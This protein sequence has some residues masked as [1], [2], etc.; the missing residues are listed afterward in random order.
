MNKNAM[1]FGGA[2]V[3]TFVALVIFLFCRERVD[4]GHAGVRVNY[5]GSNA[6]VDPTFI[7]PGVVFYNPFTQGIEEYPT[8][9]KWVVWDGDEALT[10]SD[11][12]GAIINTDIALAL[13]FQ[14]DKV[15]VLYSRTRRS[16]ESIIH[17]Y[18]RILVREKIN[19]ETEKLDVVQIFGEERSKL[20]DR[21]E[22]ALNDEL[23]ELGIVV[24]TLAFQDE[25]RVSA[26]IKASIEQ[27]I[28][29]GQEVVKAEQ[30]VKQIEA[31]ARQAQAKAEGESQAV[32]IAA[33]KQAEANRVLNE[34]LTP[35]LIQYEALQKWDGKL[36]TVSGTGAVPFVNLK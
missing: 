18:L 1:F 17:E 16:Y 19:R 35:E 33:Q 6:G 3:F 26:S 27:V 29:A 36:P 24:S 25:F 7:P 2:V 8:T 11:K 13:H 28:V 9:E 12:N 22:Q 4:F 23:K 34:S 20:L 10:I 15:P 5:Y 14:A 21:A 31:E 30:K 32:L